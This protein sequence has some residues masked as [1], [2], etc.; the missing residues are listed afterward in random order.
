MINTNIA[1]LI[2]SSFFDTARKVVDTFSPNFGLNKDQV[3]IYQIIHAPQIA[4]QLAIKY[5]GTPEK[6][7]FGVLG[8][9][10]FSLSHFKQLASQLKLEDETIQSQFLNSIK[11]IFSHDNHLFNYLNDLL[12]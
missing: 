8:K 4:S 5:G 3:E 1:N 6:Y 12:N 7:I 10:D 2:E 9:F 11:Q